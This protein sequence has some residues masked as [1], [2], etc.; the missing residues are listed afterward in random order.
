[1]KKRAFIVI[2]IVLL[3]S[4]APLTHTVTVDVQVDVKP[5]AVAKPTKATMEQKHNNRLMA[6]KFARYGWKWNASE[7]KCIR[8]LFDKESKFDHLAK[9][10]QGSS[11][12]GIAQMLKE[13]S[14]DPAVQILNAYRY[15]EHRYGTPCKAWKHSQRRNW[16]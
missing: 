2:G 6:M 14:K 13:K 8:L 12:Y 15:I 5:R 4:L 10:Q 3:A 7:R 1:M 9:N 16:Y 11:A